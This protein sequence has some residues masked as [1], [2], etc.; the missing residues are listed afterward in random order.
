MYIHLKSD[1][2]FKIVF[3]VIIH[4]QE[5]LFSSKSIKIKLGK[6][7]R[8]LIRTKRRLKL[9]RR[10]I[11]NLMY[12]NEHCKFDAVPAGSGDG[13]RPADGEDSQP[14]DCAG[15]CNRGNRADSQSIGGVLP[16]GLCIG[17]DTAFVSAVSDERLRG[18]RYQIVFRVVVVLYAEIFGTGNDVF[19]VCRCGNFGGTVALVQSE[20]ARNGNALYLLYGVYSA[21]IFI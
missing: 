5:T 9:R 2:L 21:R 8:K 3:R 20:K 1:I 7:H 6:I 4:K 12:G 19:A 10:G 17:N 14:T 13:I 15:I 16:F 11:Y 18:R